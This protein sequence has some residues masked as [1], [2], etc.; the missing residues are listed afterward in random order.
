MKT[1][2]LTIL[3]LLPL[4]TPPILANQTPSQTSLDL[5]WNYLKNYGKDFWKLASAPLQWNASDWG[6]LI[7]VFGLTSGFY[8]LDKDI[9]KIFHKNHN[10]WNTLLSNSFNY[11]GNGYY[12]LPTLAGMYAV[13]YYFPHSKL[14]QTA[15]LSLES[16]LFAGGLTNLVKILAH[17]HRPKRTKSPNQWDGP[18][19]SFSHIS[20]PSGHTTVAFAVA[21][22]FSL[23]YS[24]HWLIPVIAYTSA[25]LTGLSRIYRNAHWSSD[26][27]FGAAVGFFIA[28]AIYSFHANNNKPSQSKSFS[29][30]PS[31]Q[32]HQFSVQW[33]YHF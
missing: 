10:H 26:V 16:F 12:V 6:Q 18:D 22:I 15:L 23:E 13:G 14:K 33:I 9:R 29:L 3:C 7:S 4:L 25:T 24:D 17:R 21:T 32:H 19:F 2:S 30:Y 31:Y 20:F 1:F 27:F 8:F 28:K 11:L 5:N